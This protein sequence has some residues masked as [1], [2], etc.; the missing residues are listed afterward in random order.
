PPIVLGVLAMEHDY[1]TPDEAAAQVRKVVEALEKKFDQA[2]S[3]FTG[4]ATGGSHVMPEWS[5]DIL[6][7][8]VPEGIA[9]LFGMGDD[10]VGKTPKVLFDDK[11]DLQA[12]RARP[13]IGMHGPNEYNEVLR[14]DG[15]DQGIYDLFFKVD[16]FID[17]KPKIV[18]YALV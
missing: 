17:T 14:V 1:G 15:G 16:L 6:V 7:G 2:A 9:A 11:A 12:L 4:A 18:P 3:T 13:I 8:W 5:R 10:L